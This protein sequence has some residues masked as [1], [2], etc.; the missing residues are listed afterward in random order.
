M[1]KF[2][3]TEVQKQA[4]P[5]LKNNQYSALYGGARSGKTTIILYALIIR[6]C[7][8]K[9]THAIIRK[10]FN[11]L[12][13]TI[14]NGSFPKVMHLCFPDLKVHYNRS[15]YIATFPNGS[16]IHFI[17]VDDGKRADKVLGLELSSIYFNE[18]S[19]IDY[20]SVQVVISRLAEKNILKKRVYYDLNPSTR[21]HWT[22]DLFVRKLN[23]VSSEPLENPEKYGYLQMNPVDNKEHIDPE[24]LKILEAM[25]EADRNRFLHGM[26]SDSSDGQVYYSFSRDNHVGEVKREY[27]TLFVASDYNVDPMCS[28]VFQYDG[29]KFYIL[30]EL[31]LRNS[32]T[33]KLI[34]ELKKR[35]YGGAR[36]IPDSTAKNRKTSG[37]SDIDILKGAGFAIE[38][39][40][41]P[42]VVDRVNNANRIFQDNKIVIDP[43][44]KKLIG[45]L[46]KVV[47]RDGKLDQKTD[48]L[49]THISDALGYGLWKLDPIGYKSGSR[50]KFH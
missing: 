20:G 27:G 29:K 24:Y 9:S 46:E 50:I 38:Y 8:A 37:K 13:R 42:Y 1:S 39:T 19:E 32:D 2:V 22:Y 36:V 40:R 11:S 28:V 44:C 3:K 16:E 21:S 35:G 30:D 23:P 43:K 33:Y 31:F 41:N 12:K 6:A 34:D 48:P 26:F 5:V 25:P 18:A 17:G 45:D 10:T 49:L 47:W 15:D 4:I 7:K 14:F